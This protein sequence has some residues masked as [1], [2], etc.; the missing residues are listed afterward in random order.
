MYDCKGEGLSFIKGG[1]IEI[2][3]EELGEKV[4]RYQDD[5]LL[6]RR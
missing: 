2:Y 6:Q 1:E 5:S 4:V 3:G